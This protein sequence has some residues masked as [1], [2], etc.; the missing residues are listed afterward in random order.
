MG[1]TVSVAGASG[2]AGGELLR[3][4]S[5]HPHLDLG[6]VTAHSQA[7]ARLGQDVAPLVEDATH[8]LGTWATAPG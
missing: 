2:Y 6:Q 3:L 8:D 4:I 1:L 7:G 5:A